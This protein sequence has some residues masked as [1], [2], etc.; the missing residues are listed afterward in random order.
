MD[1]DQRDPDTL[2]VDI[3][4]WTLPQ[5]RRPQYRKSDLNVQVHDDHGVWHRK[6]VGG[7]FTACGDPIV[8]RL[9]QL[10][11]QESYAGSICRAGCFSPFELALS[12]RINEA[13]K[14]EE[15]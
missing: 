12:E 7:D 3:D 11:R 1:D 6:A 14:A 9:R 5:Q 10:H 2:V 15:E 8:H 4:S 13:T